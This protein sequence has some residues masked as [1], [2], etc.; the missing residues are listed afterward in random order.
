MREVHIRAQTAPWWA[1]WEGIPESAWG[2][3]WALAP[4]RTMED[5]LDFP[6]TDPTSFSSVAYK[7]CI[8]KVRSSQVGAADPEQPRST[9]PKFASFCFRLQSFSA[10]SRWLNV[11]SY[12]RKNLDAI[13]LRTKG[14][15]LPLDKVRGSRP[16]FYSGGGFPAVICP[17]VLKTQEDTLLHTYR[18]DNAWLAGVLRLM[19]PGCISKAGHLVC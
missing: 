3:V 5:L 15:K 8:R 4:R 18:T 10:A 7:R 19:P 14:R 6:T 2:L 9:S 11:F 1:F 16:N 13:L 12:R 17:K